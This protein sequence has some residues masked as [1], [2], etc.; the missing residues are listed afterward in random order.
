MQPATQPARIL[1]FGIF[2]VDLRAGELRK[3][4]LKVRLQE[5]PFQL[6]AALLEQPGEVVTRE[7]LRSRLWPPG[8]YVDF[9]HSLNTAVKRLRE[10]LGDSAD[11]PRFVETLTGRGYRFLA[12]VEEVVSPAAGPASLTVPP[13]PEPAAGAPRWWMVGGAVAVLLAVLAAI[14]VLNLGGWKERL[15]G[16]SARRIQSVAVL[17]LENLTGDP[18]QEYFADGMTDALITELAQIQALRVVSRTSVMQYKGRKP[19][20]KQIARELNVDAVVEGTVRRS[21]DQV[22]ITAQLI[23]AATDRHLWAKPYQRALH[24][25]P[26]LQNELARDIVREIGIRL[27]PQEQARLASSA[28]PVHPEAYEMYLQ[29][30]F[31]YNKRSLA[32]YQKAIQYFQQASEKDPAYAPAYSGLSDSYRMFGFLGPSAPREVMPKAEGAAIKA[33][34]LDDRLAEAHAALA[35]VRYRYSWDWS[36]SEKEFRRALELNPNYAEGRRQYSVFLRTVGR[37][38]EAI[39]EA[40]RARELDPLS[41]VM[42]HALAQSLHAA[43]RYDEALAQYRK[44]LEM[45]PNFVQAHFDLGRL[46]EETGDF[47]KGIPEYETAIRLSGPIP[48]YR[49]NLGH[50]YAVS[51]K[52]G[53]ARRILAELKTLSKRQYVSPVHMALVS[54]GLGEKEQA[55]EWLEK[56]YEARSFELIQ[57]KTSP[58]FYGLRSHPR[59]IDLFRRV[60]LPP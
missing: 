40:R 39:A 28:R 15:S 56:A 1:R 24:D 10:A 20:L 34:E 4:G 18:A 14:V 22:W 57:V 29:G 41:V 31:H 21:G 5:Q 25:V 11:N 7:E 6:L 60:G 13:G 48:L 37:P 36:G 8:T 33:L 52:R 54:I 16:A 45:D 23:D 12:P 55:L 2:E 3:S 50:A 32:G 46:Y 42:N 49:A 17:P 51:G 44:M 47:S 30:R 26:A 27:R 58:A 35:A 38:E 9:D 43:R 53:E 59:F 19:P